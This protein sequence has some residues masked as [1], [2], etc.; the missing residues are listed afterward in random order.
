M[1]MNKFMV[2]GIL[3]SQCIQLI[4]IVSGF[5]LT[6]VLFIPFFIFGHFWQRSYENIKILRNL[7]LHFARQDGH[8]GKNER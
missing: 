3:D 8:D 2:H 7:C 4:I 6:Y 5:S 1:I